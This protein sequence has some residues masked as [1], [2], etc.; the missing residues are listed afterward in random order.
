MEIQYKDCLELAIV[1]A[2][3]AISYIEKLKDNKYK[4]RASILRLTLAYHL[5]T[6]SNQDDK[7]N[8]LRL[9]KENW[10]AAIKEKPSALSQKSSP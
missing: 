3:S 8:A 9:V 7:Y 10:E 1:E 4:G 5:A 2:E 6:R